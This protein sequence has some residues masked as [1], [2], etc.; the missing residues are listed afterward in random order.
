MQNS[1]FN[2]KNLQLYKKICSSFKN[3][4][5]QIQNFLHSISEMQNADEFLIN[6]IK[7]EKNYEI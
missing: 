1:Q 5:S 3:Y 2:Q 4:K 7:N 6:Q